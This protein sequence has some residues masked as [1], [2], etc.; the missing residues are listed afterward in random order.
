MPIRITSTIF[1]ALALSLAVGSAC[2]DDVLPSD[3]GDNRRPDGPRR[4]GSDSDRGGSSDDGGDDSQSGGEADASADDGDEVDASDVEGTGDDGSDVDNGSDVDDGGSS[5]TCVPHPRPTQVGQSCTDTSE[6]GEGRCVSI[7]REPGR[8]IC[9]AVCTKTVCEDACL[10]TERCV[11]LVDPQGDDELDEDGNVNGVCLVGAGI[12]APDYGR[13][14]LG[15]ASCRED[16]I[17]STVGIYEDDAFCSQECV[18]SCPPLGSLPGAC[19][20][21]SEG[22]PD[23]CAVLCSPTSPCPSTH[24]CAQVSADGHIC[25]PL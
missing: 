22:G 24:R 16:S 9:M 7:D 17:C 4:G 25:L 12:I 5:G 21:S 2:S 3:M 23:S 11:G 15:V 18:D 13:C 1:L 8:S 20:L 19:V 10:E 14:G 6:C